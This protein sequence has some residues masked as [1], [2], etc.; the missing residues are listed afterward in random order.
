M[1]L[2]T[3]LTPKKMPVGDT[4]HIDNTQCGSGG[5]LGKSNR[6]VIPACIV[7]EIRKRYPDKNNIYTGYLDKYESMR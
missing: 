1:G 7:H 6:K 5:Y 2:V 4:Q 3:D